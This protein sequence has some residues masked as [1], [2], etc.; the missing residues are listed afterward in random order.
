[1]IVLVLFE[2]IRFAIPINLPSS[3]SFTWRHLLFPLLGR[4]TRRVEGRRWNTQPREQG[5]VLPL[6]WSALLLQLCLLNLVYFGLPP[7]ASGSI[8]FGC[9]RW[10]GLQRLKFRL[11]G[12]VPRGQRSHII[13][14]WWRD[15]PWS[16][17]RVRWWWCCKRYAWG[18][19]LWGRSTSTLRLLVRWRL[20]RLLLSNFFSIQVWSGYQEFVGLTI[21]WRGGRRLL[22]WHPQYLQWVIFIYSWDRYRVWWAWMYYRGWSRW[23]FWRQG[24]LI[25][26]RDVH[27]NLRRGRKFLSRFHVASSWF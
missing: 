25:C 7:C 27:Q 15:L 6:F 2:I 14:I 24:R 12:E 16:S 23:C 4:R 20:P 13:R 21:L 11:L 9:C 3:S 17:H 5:G 8:L 1:M 26:H 18:R 19:L 22:R 10:E